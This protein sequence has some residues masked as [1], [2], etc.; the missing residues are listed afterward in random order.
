MVKEI[1][2]SSVFTFHESKSM[3][4]RCLRI[5]DVEDITCEVLKIPI[6]CTL[7]IERIKTPVRGVFC[8]HFQC[9]DLNNFLVLTSSSVNPR[10]LC[11]LCKQPAYNFK[12]DIIIGSII[13]EYAK[14]QPTEIMFTKDG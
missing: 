6:I 4:D 12:Y 14:F 8:S 9:F 1:K 11:P 2:E 5:G 10:W 7:T 3:L 13:E